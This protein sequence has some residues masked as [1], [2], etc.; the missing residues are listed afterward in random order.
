[1]RVDISPNFPPS[2]SWTAAAE[3]GL[4]AFGFGMSSGSRSTRMIISDAYDHQRTF[5]KK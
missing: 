2:S 5:L 4:G 3:F 1:M